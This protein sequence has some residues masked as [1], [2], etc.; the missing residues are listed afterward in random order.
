MCSEY[1]QKRPHQSR[2]RPQM[3]D[4]IHRQPAIMDK[5][6]AMLEKW[7][8]DIIDSVKTLASLDKLIE[9][10][11]LGQCLI[12]TDGSA[13][14]NMMSFAWKIIDVSSKA[15]FCHAG[16]AIDKELPFRA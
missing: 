2:S 7:K 16:P 9:F 4:I 5:Y 8:Q 12:A 14:D 13:S 11:Q 10:V 6:T 1:L 3:G 15:Y